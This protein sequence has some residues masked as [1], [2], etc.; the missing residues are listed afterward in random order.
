MSVTN[1]ELAN[2][3]ETQGQEHYA[4]HLASI[5]ENNAVVSTEDIVNARGVLMV[6]KGARIDSQASLKL[7]RHK[8]MR[9]LEEQIQIARCLDGARIRECLHGLLDKYPD[10]KQIHIA[11]RF[12]IDCD[13]LIRERKL[14]QLL[15]QKMTVQHQQQPGHQP[16]ATIP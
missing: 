10:L 9:P 7:A 2:T 8:L 14:N 3:F 15:V 1:P 4:N 12:E 11:S 16:G 5:N 6:R 13:Y